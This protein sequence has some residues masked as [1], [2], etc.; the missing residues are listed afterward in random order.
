MAFD[1]EQ[2]VA[3]AEEFE[4]HYNLRIRHPERD[5]VYAGFTQ[6]SEAFRQ[7]ATAHVQ[8]R[9]AEGERCTL[10]YFAGNAPATQSPL[11]VFIH[12]GYWRALNR[13][14]FSF[15]AEPYVQRGVSVALIGY[16]LAP[17][18][19]LTE[20]VEQC[21][22]AM[23]WLSGHAGELGFDRDRVVL[24]GH[25]AGGHLSAMMAACD[26]TELAGFRA[27]AIVPL[28][29]VFALEPLLLTS[30]NHDVRMT[31]AE[32]RDMSPARCTR[33]HTRS[34]LVAVGEKETEGF[35]RQSAEF[36]EHLHDLQ[37][38]AQFHKVAGRTHFDILE[39]LAG[40]GSL[41]FAQVERLLI[42]DAHADPHPTRSAG[43]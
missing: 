31:P 22:N 36:V 30:V 4:S 5:A 26:P 41:L 25:S 9:Y 18:V 33:F 29:G 15:I 12:G 20:I 43:R 42:A 34:F 3:L 39:D 17:K 37:L 6:R 1:S 27:S 21:K 7:Q 11:L 8:A 16:D 38:P 13:Q 28:S 14:I 24:S 2:L 40:P 19:R 35:I 10:D 23:R 32:A